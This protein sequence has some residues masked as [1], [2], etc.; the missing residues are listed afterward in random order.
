MSTRLDDMISGAREL[1]DTT[2]T[3]DADRLERVRQGTLRRHDVRVRRER[4]LRRGLLV[5]GGAG[6][7]VLGLLGPASSAP[8]SSAPAE[9][10]AA[11]ATTTVGPAPRTDEAL[12]A[13]WMS[14]AGY[15]R[16]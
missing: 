10:E 3:W 5:A 13:R 11:N 15:A 7:L 2:R 6:L 12:A 16:D 8:A 9:R 14:D 4:A 1:G